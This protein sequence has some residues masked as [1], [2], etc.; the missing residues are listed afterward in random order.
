MGPAYG[1]FIIQNLSENSQWKHTPTQ[2]S[3]HHPS[4]ELGSDLDNCKSHQVCLQI[5]IT[6]CFKFAIKREIKKGFKS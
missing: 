4:Y 6:V 2:P 1:H 3:T 5:D